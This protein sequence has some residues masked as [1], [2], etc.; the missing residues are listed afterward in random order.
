MNHSV[1]LLP[2][3]Y[4]QRQLAHERFRLWFVVW[5]LVAATCAGLASTQFARLRTRVLRLESLRRQ[6]EPIQEARDEIDKLQSRIAELQQREKLAFSLSDEQSMLTVVGLLSRSARQCNG[7]VAVQEL[8]LDR[9]S[10]PGAPAPFHRVLMLDGVA[11]GHQAV[12]RFAEE[13]KNSGAF[14]RVE[15]KQTGSDELNGHEA[16][17]YRMECIF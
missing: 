13:L 2:I 14:E 16:T 4:R 8:R 17:T 7:D 9:R 11:T 15:L 1:N 10:A 5:L 6:Y 3:A 12:V